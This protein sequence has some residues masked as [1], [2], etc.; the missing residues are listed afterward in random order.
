MKAEGHRRHLLWVNHFATP[1]TEGGGTRHFELGRELV[2]RGWS[3]TIAASD[4]NLHKRTYTRR[5]TARE[6]KPITELIEGVDFRWLWAAPYRINDWH[7]AWNWLS[8]GRGVLRLDM[9]ERPDVV[10]GSSPHLFAALAA[11]RLAARLKVPFILEVRDLWPESLLAVGGRK[12]VAY[13]ILD[14]IARYLYRRA[15]RIVVLARG[16]AQH[17]EGLGIPRERIAYVPNGADV[18]AF[19]DHPIRD[20]D[21]PITFVYLGAHGPANGLDVVLEA[22]ALVAADSRI[23]IRLIGDGPIKQELIALAGARG[24]TNVQFSD[25]IPKAQVPHELASVN[26]G[27]MVLRDTQ[28]FRFGVSPNKLFDYL[29]A[30]LPVVCNVSGDTAQMLREAQAGEQ[31]DD[32]SAEALARAITRMADRTLPERLSMGKNGREWVARE[33]GRAQLAQRFEE[34]V[35]AILPKS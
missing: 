33:H 10:I 30:G 5:A 7:R 15:T 34:V 35:E 25:P 9:L 17:I 2:R 11:E 22:A 19:L 32:G 31:S 24:L 8:F 16:S 1:P 28:L 18:E 27:L 3:V 6:R 21:G 29:A 23:R 4:F 14:R 13:R 26:A 12:G 20:E